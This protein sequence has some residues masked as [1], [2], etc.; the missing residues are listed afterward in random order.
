MHATNHVT[1]HAPVLPLGMRHTGRSRG[2][3]EAD[4]PSSEGLPSHLSGPEMLPARALR[5]PLLRARPSRSHG[6]PCEALDAPENLPAEALCQVALGKLEDEVPDMPDQAPPVL[7]SRSWCRS[8]RSSNSRV[9]AARRRR[10]RSRLGTR[11]GVGG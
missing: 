9:T 3:L 11:H 5:F 4:G 1:S 8:R 7:K 6:V 2:I 10:S